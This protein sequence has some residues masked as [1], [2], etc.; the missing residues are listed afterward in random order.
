MPRL[1]GR[2]RQLQAAGAA[3]LLRL[4]PPAPPPPSGRR[5]RGPRGRRGSSG[6]LPPPLPR[7]KSSPSSSSSS[8]RRKNHTSHTTRAPT[9]KT[10]RPTM[11]IHPS[12]DIAT[13]RVGESPRRRQEP[14]FD[15]PAGDR[16]PG[17]ELE[18]TARVTRGTPP[19]VVVLGG[20]AFDLLALEPAGV[21]ELLVADPRLP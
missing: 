11:K 14:I 3:G 2:Q 9:S 18:R 17:R 5:P 19:G 20:R 12:R 13:E 16:E 6:S 21:L 1:G 4:P 15:Q 7:R 8:R 10:R